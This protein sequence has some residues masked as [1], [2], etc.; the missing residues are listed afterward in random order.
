MIFQ[1]ELT[2]FL[3][4]LISIIS[5]LAVSGKK[6]LLSILSLAI[7]IL[8]LIWVVIPLIDNGYNPVLVTF[9]S[10]LPVLSL[11]IYC[12]EGFTTLSH[13]SIISTIFCFFIVSILI[14]FS[15]WLAHFTGIVSD[16]SATVGGQMGINLPGILTAGI[17]IG[18]LGALIEMITTQVA[19]VIELR[20][21]NP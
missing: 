17:M 3:L 8:M 21:A 13:L 15:V 5:L 10:A 12:N 6:G 7:T 19:T 9:I 16:L 11:I 1:I 2:I 20:H 18:T 14:D 4:L